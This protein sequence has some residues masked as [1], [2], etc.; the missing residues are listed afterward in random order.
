MLDVFPLALVSVGVCDICLQIP[1]AI[2][3]RGV[4]Y[5]QSHA[6]FYPTSCEVVADTLVN[7]AL[8]V[9]M[10]LRLFWMSG[11]GSW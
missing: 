4:F 9:R 5:K 7:T 1:P 2:E 10:Y 3:Q 8:T 6:G 11:D